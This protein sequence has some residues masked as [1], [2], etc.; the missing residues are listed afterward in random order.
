MFWIGLKGGLISHSKTVSHGG[1]QALSFSSSN[2]LKKHLTR[3]VLNNLLS[4]NMDSAAT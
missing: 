1:N 2:A 3:N 4:R